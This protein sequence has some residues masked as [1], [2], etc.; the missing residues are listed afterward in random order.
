MMKTSDLVI[1]DKA[2]RKLKGRREVTTEIGMH[3]LIYRLRP[4]VAGIVHAHPPTA[5][6]LRAPSPFDGIG[7]RAIKVT[8]S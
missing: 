2:G 6:D 7:D 5:R 8:L 4:D 1:V 3:V